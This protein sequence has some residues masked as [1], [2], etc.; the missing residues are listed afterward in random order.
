VPLG[1][2]D[3]FTE[4]AGLRYYVNNHV[5]LTVVYRGGESKGEEDMAV[6]EIVGLEAEPSSR[7]YSGKSPADV[8]VSCG[9]RAQA[10]HLQLPTNASQDFL[11]AF[12]FA[13]AWRRAGPG[14]TR[15]SWV[16][17]G[18]WSALHWGALADQLLSL[19]LLSSLCA[20]LVWRRLRVELQRSATQAGVLEDEF[21]EETGWKLLRFDVFRAPRRPLLLA[22]LVGEG[23]RVCALALLLPLLGALGFF[24][25]AAPGSLL[26]AAAPLWSLLGLLAGFLAA[27]ALLAAASAAR[28]GLLRLSATVAIALPLLATLLTAVCG[29]TQHARGAQAP[30]ALG[31][32]FAWLLVL[33]LGWP[34]AALGAALGLRAGAGAGTGAEAPRTN[35]LPRLIPPQPWY[36]RALP[37]AALGGALVYASAFVLVYELRIALFSHGVFY[38]WGFALLSVLFTSILAAQVCVLLCFFQVRFSLSLSAPLSPSSPSPLS[39]SARGGECSLR[40]VCL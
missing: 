33:L 30:S 38:L 27:R 31:Y 4:G 34:L 18:G 37:S 35:L 36:L 24:D 10:P 23:A 20:L 8:G 29:I 16:A 11:F 14:E 32:V 15:Q 2:V 7:L 3:F 39:V 19:L 25:F 26:T 40:T 6:Y 1:W 28:P 17:S 9:L 22:L 13:V 5:D 21:Q 12:T